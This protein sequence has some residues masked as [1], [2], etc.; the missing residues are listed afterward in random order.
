MKYKRIKGLFLLSIVLIGTLLDTSIASAN[1]E[2]FQNRCETSISSTSDSSESGGSTTGSVGS[3]ETEGTEA[4]KIAQNMWNYWKNKGFGGSAISGVL[5]NVAH[6]GGFDITDR[7][8]GHFGNTSKDSGISEGNVP[9]TGSGYPVGKTG[10]VE[11]GGGHY[12]FTPYSK[13]A[14]IGDANWKSTEKQSDYVWDSEVKSASWLQ[15]YITIDS[16]DKAVEVWF[17]KYE[18]GA[19]LNPAKVDSGKKAYQVFGGAN[20][21][22]DSALAG[23]TDT[24]TKGEEESKKSDDG[25]QTSEQS[26]SKNSA[27]SSEIIG[28]AKELLGYFSYALVHGEANIGTIDN[29]K[30]NGITDCSGFVWLILARTGYN[31]PSNMGW[32][33]GSMEADAKGSHQ[34]LEEVKPSEA[35]AGDIVIVNTGNGAGSNGHTAIL[36]EDWKANESDAKNT[37]K[38]IQ[39]GGSLTDGVNESIFGNSFSLLVDGSSGA[40]TTTLA[41]PIKK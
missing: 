28:N 36:T 25:C 20:V 27:S 34:W 2:G 18:R 24:A 32:F 6:E 22:G 14:P 19:S 16:V 10:Q 1:F 4:N 17:T 9:A 39:M 13:F 40:H 23:A 41:R 33:T 8:E 5:G 3:W 12:Q 7:A 26:N 15:D 37:T 38:I 31:V 35:K 30:K 11:G 21:K 29:P